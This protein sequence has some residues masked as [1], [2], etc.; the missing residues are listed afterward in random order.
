MVSSTQWARI[1]ALNLSR[2]DSEGRLDELKIECKERQKQVNERREALFLALDE[3]DKGTAPRLETL[4]ASKAVLGLQRD[5]RRSYE[6]HELAD[7]ERRKQADMANKFMA[8]LLEQLSKADSEADLF[9]KPP[10]PTEAIASVLFVPLEDVV[11]VPIAAMLNAAG[12]KTCDDFVALQTKGN[13]DELH[14]REGVPKGVV[15]YAHASIAMFLMKSVPQKAD[16]NIDLFVGSSG[17]RPSLDSIRLPEQSKPEQP[18]SEQPKSEQVKPQ[19]ASAEE[20]KA[21][22]RS[23]ALA[24]EVP[25]EEDL[26][27]E[28]LEPID[29]EAGRP[30]KHKPTAQ[31]EAQIEAKANKATKPRK[32]KKADP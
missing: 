28:D 23:R 2:Q 31:I 14:K 7:R 20:P 13:L 11:G 18:K 25:T 30:K 22:K 29:S 19:Q 24:Q 8:S 21:P 32:P 3:E 9:T 17:M 1:R 27:E 26:D 12:L 6:A 4:A 15:D 5:F 16:A 10:D